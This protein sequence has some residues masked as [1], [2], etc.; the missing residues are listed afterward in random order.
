MI[1]TPAIAPAFAALLLA[2][3]LAACDGDDSS[4]N[5][6]SITINTTGSDGNMVAGMDGKTGKLSVNLPG[7]IGGNITLPK[8]KF[9]AEDFDL[10]GVHLYP[11]STI[12]GMNVE[13]HDTGTGKTDKGEVRIAFESPAAPAK[14]QA[15]FLDKLSKDAK[16]DIKADGTG[17]SGV[18]DDKQPFRMDLTADGA[19]KSKG[20]IVI[21]S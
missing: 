15:W 17:L 5:G 10:N 9:N 21:G 19:D 13:A 8:F 6:T 16:F 11:G 20:T 12:S 4:G 14:V 3:T 7:G 18:T 2:G 1:R